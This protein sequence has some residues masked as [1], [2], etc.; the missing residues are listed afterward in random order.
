MRLCCWQGAGASENMTDNV[1]IHTSSYF[2]NKKTEDKRDKFNL[3]REQLKDFFH[4]ELK[5]F[6][7]AL[8]QRLRW[9]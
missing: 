2:M 5:N 3:L 8:C 1:F 4:R 9:R 6:L 7:I